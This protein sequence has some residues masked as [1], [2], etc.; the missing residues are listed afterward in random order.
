[1]FFYT[2]CHTGNIRYSLDSASISL[3]HILKTF[4]IKILDSI[5]TC[6]FILNIC[7]YQTRK[8]IFFYRLLR[9]ALKQLIFVGL[10]VSVTWRKGQM[11][12]NIR[13]PPRCNEIFALLEFYTA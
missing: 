10:I 4:Y 6:D 7:I 5:S 11:L 8:K 12:L 13:L 9:N 1:M 2:K 3:A